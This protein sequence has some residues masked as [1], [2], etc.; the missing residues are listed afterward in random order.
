MTDTNAAQRQKLEPHVAKS[1]ITAGVGLAYHQKDLEEFGDLGRGYN[2]WVRENGPRLRRDGGFVLLH[3][4]GQSHMLP[5]LMKSF[6]LNGMGVR[7]H[8]LVSLV[9]ALKQGGEDREDIEETPV[10]F[11]NP[12]QAARRETPLTSWQAEEVMDLIKRRVGRQS[13]VIAYWASDR[14]FEE[15]D[16]RYA[17][18]D[19]ETILWVDEYGHIVYRRDLETAGKEQP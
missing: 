6:H 4:L 12:F 7:S 18:W 14:P 8:S 3:G 15:N 9:R 1:L 19:E 17:W 16:P 2:R 10:L 5:V 11:I 13:V